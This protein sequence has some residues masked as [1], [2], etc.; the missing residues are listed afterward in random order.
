MASLGERVGEAVSEVQRHRMVA[1][2]AASP[3]AAHPGGLL[4]S[5]G[6]KFRFRFVNER[7]NPGVQGAS[8]LLL[9]WTST[10]RNAE[11]AGFSFTSQLSELRRRPANLLILDARAHRKLK[12]A[13]AETIPP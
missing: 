10:K 11:G 13:S 9:S 3:A 7:I 5:D 1:L 2:A 12:G 6:D 4:R 8:A